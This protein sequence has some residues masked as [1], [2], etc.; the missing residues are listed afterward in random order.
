MEGT[1]EKYDCVDHI[2]Q[3]GTNIVMPAFST[4]CKPNPE[5]FYGVFLPYSL[6]APVDEE[7]ESVYYDT[8]S[9]L[10][11]VKKY[12]GSRFK[13]FNTYEEAEDFAKKWACY[14]LAAKYMW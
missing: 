14:C 7:I 5:V 13:G 2:Q 4:P 8:A 11:V 1:T 10:T 12:R 6:E 3:N 9:C